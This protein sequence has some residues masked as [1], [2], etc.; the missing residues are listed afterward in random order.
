MLRSQCNAAGEAIDQTPLTLAY[1][2]SGP[3]KSSVFMRAMAT[4][5][6]PARA[7]SCL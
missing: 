4:I 7:L 1:R 5:R 3:G 6:Q 2:Q